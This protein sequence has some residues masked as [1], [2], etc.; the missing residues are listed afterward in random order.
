MKNTFSLYRI[1][2]PIIYHHIFQNHGYM[3]ALY[4]YMNIY[5]SI[6]LVTVRV[7][8]TDI[9]LYLCVHIYN[10]DIAYPFICE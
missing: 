2:A 6:Y 10:F 3:F 1:Y 5:V 4:G 7:I 9:F 8:V